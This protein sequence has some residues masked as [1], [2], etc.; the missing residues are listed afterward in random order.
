MSDSQPRGEPGEFEETV[1]EQEILKIFDAADEPFLTAGEVA[2]RLP[3]S[4]QAVSHRLNEMRKEGLVGK[5]QVGT[6]AIGWWAEVAPEPVESDVPDY[7]EAEPISQSDM[8]ERLGL[9]G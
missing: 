4:L 5:K 9:D 7:E 3:V 8:K 6:R 1:S 2:Q